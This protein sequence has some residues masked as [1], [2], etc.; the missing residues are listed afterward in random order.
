MLRGSPTH[1]STWWVSRRRARSGGGAGDGGC[2]QPDE[3]LAHRCRNMLTIY[4]SSALYREI[5]AGRW[6][7][8]T[9]VE[10]YEE[11]K[12][13]VAQ[14]IFRGVRHAGGVQPGDVARSVARAARGAPCSL[15][16]VISDIGEERPRRYRVNLRHLQAVREE[17]LTWVIREKGAVDASWGPKWS[18]GGARNRGYPA[19]STLNWHFPNRALTISAPNWHSL[20]ENEKGDSREKEGGSAPLRILCGMSLFWEMGLLECPRPG[21]FRPAT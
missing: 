7:E 1:S 20:R 21:W 10:K 16:A 4:R 14:L 6:H 19:I 17:V 3:P 8:A 11:V 9:E 12:E 15:D 5:E 18:K 2:L 13:L